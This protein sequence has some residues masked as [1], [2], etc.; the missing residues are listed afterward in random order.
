MS[1]VVY[2]END[3]LTLL[4][5]SNNPE[6]LQETFAEEIKKRREIAQK[7]SEDSFTIKTTL[8]ELKKGFKDHPDFYEE[9]SK[10]EKMSVEELKAYNEEQRQFRKENR[11]QN[12]EAGE[13]E[14]NLQAYAE[15]LLLQ[16]ENKKELADANH[17]AAALEKY[18]E[19][20]RNYG[21]DF[22]YLYQLQQNVET[23]ERFAD[24]DEKGEIRS[25]KVKFN[26][27]DMPA[28]SGII[29]QAEKL[30]QDALGGVSS[31]LALDVEIDGGVPFTLSVKPFDE[32]A[33]ETQKKMQLSFSEAAIQQ[34]TSGPEEENKA[35]I[36]RIFKFCADNGISTSDM[37]LP[38]DRDGNVQVDEKL[39]DLMSQVRE[40]INEENAKA[41]REA[42]Q[43]R[44]EEMRSQGLI[45]EPDDEL[46][47][48][49]DEIA[50]A[51]IENVGDDVPFAENVLDAD[52]T[53][54]S[55]DK[56][57]K[58]AEFQQENEPQAASLTEDEQQ[59][60]LGRTPPPAPR[61]PAP[62]RPA[63]TSTQNV[64]E[65]M[66]DMMIND[67]GRIE[68]KSFFKRRQ[69]DWNV[70]IIYD[71]DVKHNKPVEQDKD[72]NI[73]YNYAVKIFFKVD[74]N[75]VLH[76]SYRTPNG[77][78]LDPLYS[79]AVAGKLKDMKI[80]HFR[81][82]KGWRNDDVATWRKSLAEKGI[83]PTGI[84]LNRSKVEGMLEAAK[85]KL[86]T[87]EYNKYKYLRNF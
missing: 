73:K 49:K 44:E 72:G 2:A 61:T 53:G 60:D 47:P 21:D 41:E 17:E 48:T 52:N 65:L 12:K 8:N 50:G 37:S 64:E 84:S 30:R 68:D 22:S 27:I 11:K 31:T 51:T 32:Q 74:S 25:V 66:D 14:D 7:C 81:I 19:L 71:H 42:D 23:R 9:A 83:V 1:N 77:K 63:P 36:E 39:H 28:N 34:L 35:K 55:K 58:N 76:L 80:T 16:T 56:S 87:E 59:N 46:L 43:R 67:I 13:T 78:K 6:K 45:R 40:K 86:S 54:K 57:K 85:K 26:V 38:T 70:Y 29:A 15:Q 3:S 20:S 5:P 62:A 4:A 33:N 79:D 10:L 82:P 69:G 18:A 24:D 75:G